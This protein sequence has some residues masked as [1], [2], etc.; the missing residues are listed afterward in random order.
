[1]ASNVV[2]PGNAQDDDRPT[3]VA[4]KYQ[5]GDRVSKGDVLCEGERDKATFEVEAPESGVLL[6]RAYAEGDSVPAAATLAVIGEPGEEIDQIEAGAELPKSRSVEP[7]AEEDAGT[8]SASPS[9][10]AKSSVPSASADTSRRIRIS[11]RARKLAERHN[12]DSAAVTGS[13]SGG[14][15]VVRDIEEAIGGARPAPR[16]GEVPQ[17]SQ[18]QQTVRVTGMRRTI[19]DRM[20]ESLSTTAQL[21]LHMSADASS[22]LS[23]RKKLKQSPEGSGLESVTINDLVMYAVSRVLPRFP[24]LNSHFLGDR[25]TEYSAVNLGMAVDTSRGLMVPVIRGANHLSLKQLS[26]RAAELRQA[27]TAGTLSADDMSTGTF[28]VTNLG[29]LGVEYFTPVLNVPQVAIL[30]VG[31]IASKP[32]MDRE[33]VRFLPHIGLSLTVDHQAVDGAPAAVFLREMSQGLENLELLLAE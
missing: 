3:L 10:R 29:A 25:I 17:V 13:G 14:R 31:A 33:E 32:V 20:V 30:G 27:C 7:V 28:T 16:T 4:W 1:V 6:K 2:M 11:P 9:T 22:L 21:T 23:Y 12:V 15:I 19:A 8:E 18:P 5:E 26:L 24:R